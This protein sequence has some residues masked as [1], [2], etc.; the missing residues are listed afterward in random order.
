MTSSKWIFHRYRNGEARNPKE[1]DQFR[2]DSS[3]LADAL[4]REC[5][6]NSLDAKAGSAPVKVR[7]SFRRL[8]NEDARKLKD[9]F[10]G[11]FAEHAKESGL[12]CPPELT[13]PHILLIEDFNTTGLE[14]EIDHPDPEGNFFLFTHGVG[15]TNKKRGKRGRHGLGKAVFP[16]SSRC[17]TFFATTLRRNEPYPPHLSGQATLKF[18]KVND[19][20]YEAPAYFADKGREEFEIPVKDEETVTSLCRLFG[21]DRSSPGLSVVIPFPDPDLDPK[22]IRRSLLENYY[23][24][25]VGGQLELEIFDEIID[26]SN[27]EEKALALGTANFPTELFPFIRSIL[28]RD[29]D[30]LLEV[31]REKF[32]DD[33]FPDDQAEQLRNALLQGEII[34]I[35]IPLEARRKNGQKV[36][37]HLRIFLQQ[38]HGLEK[39]HAL[40][41]REGLVLTEEAR[42]FGTRRALGIVLAQNDGIAELLGDAEN[43]SHR[44]WNASSTYVQERWHKRD[45][46]QVIRLAR[47]CLPTLFDPL[48]GSEELRDDSALSSYFRLPPEKS[49]TSNSKTAGNQDPNNPDANNNTGE[50]DTPPSIPPADTRP[51]HITPLPHAT[52][53][54]VTVDPERCNTFTVAASYKALDKKGAHDPLDF[55]F[56]GSTKLAPK[57]K[58]TNGKGTETIITSPNTATLRVLGDNDPYVD[59]TGFDRNRDLHIDVRC[60]EA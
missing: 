20:Y 44:G 46:E 30:G 47:Q 59:F 42:K 15:V 10:S 55:D 3:K 32:E 14:G 52:G 38:P 4:A 35:R 36:N 7:F 58:I 6:Q 28:E 27:A 50:S 8:E 51:F 53:F 18:R 29:D 11:A 45:A 21:T 19:D 54:R 48:L 12:E 60:E 25:L 43:P 56:T 34:G 57:P 24:A 41:V 37:G 26:G 9:L 49:D 17:R 22:A 31:K 5:V 2:D 13:G 16:L 39:G 1:A 40:Y 23:F 33:S